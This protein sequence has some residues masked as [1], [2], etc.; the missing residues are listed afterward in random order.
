MH[1]QSRRRAGLL[2]LGAILAVVICSTAAAGRAA[3]P[4][5]AGTWHGTYGGAYSG[6]FT[7]HWTAT[8]SLLHGTIHLSSPSGTYGITG[9]IT[10]TGK[11]HFGAVDVGAKYTGTATAKSMSG[12]YTSPG[13]GGPW[14][15]HR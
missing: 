1:A 5:I 13:G 7:I 11:I 6:T 3:A 2:V 15:A 12:R 9:A 8:G 4:R 10:R 14:S